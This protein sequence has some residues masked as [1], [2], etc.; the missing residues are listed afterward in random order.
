VGGQ[1]LGKELWPVPKDD[2]ALDDIFQ[3]LAHF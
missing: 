1:I 3:A 2:R